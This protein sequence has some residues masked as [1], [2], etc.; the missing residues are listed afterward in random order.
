MNLASFAKRM[1]SIA[2]SVPRETNKVKQKVAIAVDQAVVR[3]TPVDTGKARS[4]WVASLGDPETTV[5][6]PYAP[7]IHGGIGETANAQTAM[8]QAEAVIASCKPGVPIAIA[9]NVDYI[10]KL[11]TGSSR[12]APAMFV[13]AAVVAGSVTVAEAKLVLG[14]ETLP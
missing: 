13:E 7:T 3:G 12:Q 9:N 1:I 11:N 2:D 10:G 6:P 4:N 8:H 5:I 14:K